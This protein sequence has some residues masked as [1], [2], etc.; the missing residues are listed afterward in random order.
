MTTTHRVPVPGASIHYEVRGSGPVLVIAG[1]PMA[2]RFFGPLADALAGDHTVITHDPRGISNS[3]LADPTAPGDPNERADDIV[4]ILDAVGAEQADV[5]GSSGGAVTGLALVTRHPSRVRTLVAHEPPLLTILPDAAEQMAITDD[6]VAT[7][8]RDGIGPAFGKFMAQAG[9]DQTGGAPEPAADGTPPDAEWQPSE[10]YLADSVRMFGYDILGT[11]RYRPDVAALTAR[12]GQ[13][14]L[15]I[16]AE[17]GSLFTYR[18]TAALAA[19]LGLEMVEFPGDHGGFI[20]EPV[21][22]AATLRSVL[23]GSTARV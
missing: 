3:P 10:Q 11:T 6:I 9:F 16:G 20:P 17:S 14:V 21:A 8:H 5:F 18:T 12:P 2:A 7:F 19:L 15:G 1:S 23:A 13:V 22:F 4:A